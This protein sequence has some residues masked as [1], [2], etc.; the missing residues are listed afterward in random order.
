L[1]RRLKSFGLGHRLVDHLEVGGHRFAFFV[2]DETQGMR[3][4]AMQVCA[5]VF[6]KTLSIAYGKPFNP[7][8]QA[9]KLSSTT[10]DFNSSSN[11][12]WKFAPSPWPSQNPSSSLRH[13]RLT[14]TAK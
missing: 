14:Q 9:M 4:R 6:G 3:R 13:S 8:A 11:C 10:L 2:A 7:F 12:K 1:G 5:A